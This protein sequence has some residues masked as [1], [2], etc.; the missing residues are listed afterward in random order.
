[1]SFIRFSVVRARG[2]GGDRISP[3]AG[4]FLSQNPLIEL[5]FV[6]LVESR[7]YFSPS[8]YH[9]LAL[10]YTHSPIFPSTRWWLKWCL[11]HFKYLRLKSLSWKTLKMF[12]VLK[13]KIFKKETM[14]IECVNLKLIRNCCTF[15]L[16]ICKN[17]SI[18]SSQKVDTIEM[19]KK[20]KA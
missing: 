20:E 19:T 16:Q 12:S 8:F 17:Q 1:M 9:L 5:G 4:K 7:K 2:G 15:N 11:S 18:A 14:R 10:C 6:S 13:M 3:S